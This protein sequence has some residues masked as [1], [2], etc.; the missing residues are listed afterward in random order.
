MRAT[1]RTPSVRFL[2]TPRG[3][4]FKIKSELQGKQWIPERRFAEV[5]VTVIDKKGKGRMARALLDSS[6]SKSLIQFESQKQL[7]NDI[8]LSK[9]DKII[10]SAIGF[11]PNPVK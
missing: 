9:R 1:P 4:L 6:C 5:L 8:H 11:A 2:P 7:Y 10:D 3:K